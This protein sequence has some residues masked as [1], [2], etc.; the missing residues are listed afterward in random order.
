LALKH[1]LLLQKKNKALPKEHGN[2]AKQTM[3][4]KTPVKG[5]VNPAAKPLKPCSELSWWQKW[6]DGGEKFTGIPMSWP[7]K[8]QLELL[9]AQQILRDAAEALAE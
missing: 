8:E 2:A 7:C 6:V 5:K 3:D 4:A 1:I 9:K